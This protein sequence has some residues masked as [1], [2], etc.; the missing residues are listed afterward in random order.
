MDKSI[1][2]NG[3]AEKILAS[4]QGR[5]VLVLGDVMLDRYWFGTVNRI[6]PEAP[7]PVVT[8]RSSVLAPGG[9]A[10]VAANIA[11]LGGTPLLVGMIGDDAAG[12]ELCSILQQRGVTSDYLFVDQKRPTTVKTR[13]V[14]H[15][16]HVVRVDEEDS[17]PA[18]QSVL[19]RVHECVSSHLAATD[20]LLISDYAKGLV[21]PALLKQIIQSTKDTDCRVVVDPKGA[22]YSCYNGAYLLTPNSVEAMAAA[23]VLTDQV[24]A[25]KAAGVHLLEMLDLNALLITQGEAGMTLFERGIAPVCFP[26]IAR[27]VYDVTGAGDTVVA[28]L[29]LALATG[30]SLPIAVQLANLAAGIAVEQVGTTAVTVDQLRSTLNSEPGRIRFAATS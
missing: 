23:R 10:N 30:A 20:L 5:K 17:S 2:D 14:A 15:S 16:Q 21:L 6:S 24:D 11:S 22:D 27:T 18:S 25:V 29:S 12:R 9:A 3:T 19:S 8:K 1:V 13:I 4:F 26:A 28:A 7:V